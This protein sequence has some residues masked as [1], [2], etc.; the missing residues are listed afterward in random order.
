MQH[1]GTLCAHLKRGPAAVCLDAGAQRLHGA[2]HEPPLL[3]S[4]AALRAGVVQ[5]RGAA[6]CF[7]GARM[8][9]RT[10]HDTAT[11]C[12]ARLTMS[13]CVLPL[14]VCPYAM[15]VP[16]YPLSTDATMWL[17]ESNTSP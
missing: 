15:I 4:D 7:V 3:A 5:L 2:R 10:Q 11:R 13:V 14:P 12:H 9:G 6:W 1:A 17:Q 16:L 8:C